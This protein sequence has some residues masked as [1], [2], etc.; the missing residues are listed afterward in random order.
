MEYYAYRLKMSHACKRSNTGTPVRTFFGKNL[1]FCMQR[2]LCFQTVK[3]LQQVLK[4]HR[5]MVETGEE[6]VD[7]LEENLLISFPLS[8][9]RELF[10]FQ[11]SI[12]D[13]ADKP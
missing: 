13:T 6:C 4:L 9:G 8:F 1:C 10:E 3:F 12:H 5:S 2:P 11:K 7:V